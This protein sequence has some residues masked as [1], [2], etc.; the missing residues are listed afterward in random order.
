MLAAAALLVLGAWLRAT[1]LTPFAISHPDELSQY[2]EQANRLAT[3]HGLVPWEMRYGARNQIIPQL[4]APAM[5][6]GH[7]LAPG[8][9]LAV[10]LARGCYAALCGTAT[11]LGAWRLG[12]IASPTAAVLAL[13]IAACWWQSVLYDDL[14][15]SESLSAGLLLLAAP[16]V[17]CADAPAGALRLA[18]F[19]LGSAVVVRFQNALFAAVLAGAALRADR[20]RWRWLIE[21]GLV[22]ALVG[23]LSDLI[24]GQPPFRWV[25]VNLAMNIGAEGRAAKFGAAPWWRYAALLASDFG[26]AL[27]LIGALALA[28]G[29]RQRPLLLAATAH[30]L[31]HSLLAHKE[32]RFV[33]PSEL[34]LLV[35]AAI[36]SAGLAARMTTQTRALRWAALGCGWLLADIGALQSSGGGPVRRW[37][38]A[39]PLAALSAAQ[40]ARVCGIAV[41]NQ[42]RAH[43]VPAL[44][45]REVP[46]YVAPAGM[47]AGSAPLPADLAAAANALVAKTL[48]RGATGYAPRGCM[49]APFGQVC[50][51]IRAGGCTPAPRW[52]YQKVLERE[53]S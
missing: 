31:A 43:V 28:S 13:G 23:A 15:L 4:L 46:L 14:L 22:A 36:G 18:G 11:M 45:G 53:D 39:I 2:L 16:G 8:T 27:P 50:L 3:G 32:P 48:P 21:G 5:A 10:W 52:T 44:L 26:P 30:I 47:M 1:S 12:R 37:G 7:R 6:L 24:A 9:L 34:S 29:R 42:W 19:L 17:L 40:S 38:S 35:L 20:R 41:P 51:F 33:W 49:A 25:L